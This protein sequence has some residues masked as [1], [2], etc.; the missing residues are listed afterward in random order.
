MAAE[1]LKKVRPEVD[2]NEIG[3]ILGIPPGPV[4]GRA[5]KHLL[6]VRLDRGPIGPD[7]AREELLTW[8]AEQ[9]ESITD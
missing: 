1:E 3:R 6:A 8:W 5:Y 4:L 7:A 2:G 9:P